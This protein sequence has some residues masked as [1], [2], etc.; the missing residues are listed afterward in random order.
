MLPVRWPRYLKYVNWTTLKTT[1][2]RA[3]ELRL[4]GLS[5]EMA[6]NAMLALFPAILAILTAIGFFEESLQPTFN[7]LAEQLGQVAPEAAATLIR[8]FVGSL[9]LSNSQRLFSL[10][11]LVALWVS[12]SAMSAAMNALDQIHRIPA[13]QK[14]PFWKSKLISLGLTLGSLVLLLVA[15]FLV[16]ISDWL[17][18]MAVAASP[19]ETLKTL[20]V[21]GW[22]LL[23]WPLALGLV[24]IA[25]AFVYRY[26]PS[27]WRPKRQIIPGALFGALLWA[28]LSG[29]LRMYV[30]RF[31]QY[32]KI[33]GAVGAAIVLMLWLYLSSLALLLGDQLNVIIGKAMKP[34][35]KRRARSKKKTTP[36]AKT[37]TGAEETTAAQTE[38]AES[39]QESAQKAAETPEETET[40]EATQPPAKETKT[41][42]KTDA[43]KSASPRK[44]PQDSKRSSRTKK[45]TKTEEK[46]EDTAGETSDSD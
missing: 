40:S 39:L 43:T 13:S 8:G 6:Y 41:T 29:L 18:G 5:A 10:S 4:M 9:Q 27:R 37:K 24:A 36:Q 38:A 15:C 42:E 33:Y 17:L 21:S 46:L 30:S 31:G 20:L 32:N 7:R 3:G 12:S 2:E 26:G 11:F 44:T 19:I 23:R 16:F 1:L 35:R 34:P 22:R 28:F 14:R 25:F 45:R